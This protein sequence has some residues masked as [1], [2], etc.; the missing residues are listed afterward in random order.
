MASVLVRPCSSFGGGTTVARQL[1]HSVPSY[2][3]FLRAASETFVRTASGNHRLPLDKYFK[4][5]VQ[6]YSSE[7]YVRERAPLP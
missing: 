2:R 3:A 7:T 6:T 4:G 5:M 1:T